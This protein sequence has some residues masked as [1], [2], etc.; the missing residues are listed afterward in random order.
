MTVIVKD[1]GQ[2]QFHVIDGDKSW[3]CTQ[4]TT[5]EKVRELEGEVERNHQRVS[6]WKATEAGIQTYIDQINAGTLL[7]DAGTNPPLYLCEYPSGNYFTATKPN[8]EQRVMTQ[9]ANHTHVDTV[10][11]PELESELLANNSVLDQISSDPNGVEESITAEGLPMDI[12]SQPDDDLTVD[13]TAT[14]EGDVKYVKLRVK[15]DHPSPPEEKL[16][17]ILHKDGH[18]KELYYGDGEDNVYE[19]A[20]WNGLFAG[21]N[22]SVHLLNDHT[23]SKNELLELELI[24]T[25]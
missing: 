15:V 12:P 18:H 11:I 25:T 17:I 4:D 24:I 10:Y 5:A 19:S 3:V 7:P 16:M 21:G 14:S 8:L 22:W 9:N 20:Y 23:S 1:L 6:D 13:L 2:G